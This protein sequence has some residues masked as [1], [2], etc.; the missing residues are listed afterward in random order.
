VFLFLPNHTTDNTNRP[1]LSTDD[2]AKILGGNLARALKVPK[3][4]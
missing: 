1:G 3:D 2:K 4:A